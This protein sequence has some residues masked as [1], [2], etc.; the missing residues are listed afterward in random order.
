MSCE[1]NVKRVKTLKLE[2]QSLSFTLW[3]DKANSKGFT[4]NIAEYV[5]KDFI[6]RPKHNSPTVV[7]RVLAGYLVTLITYSRL[8]I[9]TTHDLRAYLK[10]WSV[11]ETIKVVKDHKRQI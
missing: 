5:L 9:K 4:K 11:F 7:E 2:K 8:R 1:T 6:Q 3:S 10:Q